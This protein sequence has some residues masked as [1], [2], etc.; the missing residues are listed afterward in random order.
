MSDQSIS[1][2]KVVKVRVKSFKDLARMAASSIA[3][4]QATY[5]I[6]YTN[7]SGSIIYGVLAVFRDFFKLYGI[8]LFYYYEDSEKSIPTDSNYVLVR[9]DDT[10]EKIELSKGARSGYLTVPIINLAEPPEFIK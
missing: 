3:M 10:G 1:I 8:P 7:E 2:N 6:R 4:G 5:I 9:S